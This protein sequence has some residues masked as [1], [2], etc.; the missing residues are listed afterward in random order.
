MD[1]LFSFGIETMDQFDTKEQSKFDMI[2]VTWWVGKV[3]KILEITELI[4]LVTTKLNEYNN[5]RTIGTPIC[6][7]SIYVP[8]FFFYFTFQTY[9][10]LSISS[11]KLFHL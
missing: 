3:N 2:K 5:Y 10:C 7:Y 8:P 11:F 1:G 4:I 9:S 6:L